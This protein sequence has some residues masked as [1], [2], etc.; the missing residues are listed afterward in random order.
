MLVVDDALAGDGAL[1]QAVEG[2]GVVLVG[3]D[4]QTRVLGGE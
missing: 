1:L 3:H 4:D 2:G